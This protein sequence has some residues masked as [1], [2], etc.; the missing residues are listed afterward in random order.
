[1][2]IYIYIY[3]FVVFVLVQVKKMLG[4]EGCKPE[5]SGKKLTTT[6]LRKNTLSSTTGVGLLMYLAFV[7]L[8][9]EQF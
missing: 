3:L 8:S 7:L 6:P 1:M 2:Y 9:S 4:G 5:P